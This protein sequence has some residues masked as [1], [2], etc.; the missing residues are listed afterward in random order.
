LVFELLLVILPWIVIRH[1][2]I[3]KHRKH[4]VCLCFTTRILVMIAIVVQMVIYN[5]GV[6]EFD[7]GFE[8]WPNYICTPTV[9]G[10]GIITGCVPYFRPFFDSVEA[11]LIR[12]REMRRGGSGGNGFES[13]APLPPT[14]SPAFGNWPAPKTHREDIEMIDRPAKS[15]GL[16]DMVDGTSEFPDQGSSRMPG[17]Y[18]QD[19]AIAQF[20][21]T[22]QGAANLPPPYQS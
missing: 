4:V 16:I 22:K 2:Q 21:G 8:N 18:G 20:S 17:A 1:S 11:A 19:S 7:I 6:E 12:S 5:R 10:L 3:S 14:P 15:N 13:A 9:Q